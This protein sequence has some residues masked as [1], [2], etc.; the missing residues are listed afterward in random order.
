MHCEVIRSTHLWYGL[1]ERRDTVLIQN[2]SENDIMGG[3]IVG[4][5]RAFLAVPFEGDQYPC[6]LVEWFLPV[7]SAPDPITGMWIV[8]PEREAGG[9]RKIGLV[10]LDCIVRSCLLQGVTNEKHLPKDF[11]YSDTHVAFKSFYVSK[12]ADYHTHEIY[13]L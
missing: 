4:R 10:H 12:Y 13:P 3:L 5:V 8:E 2:G 11:H 1:Y 6:A 9:R 7:G